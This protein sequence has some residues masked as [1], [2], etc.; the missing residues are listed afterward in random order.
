MKRWTRLLCVSLAV[1]LSAQTASSVQPEI[2]SETKEQAAARHQ[3]VMERRLKPHVICHRGASEFAQENTLEA[4]RATFELGGDGN[5]IDIRATKDGVLV[6]FHDDWL[7]RLL[8]AHG[9]ASEYT[10][11]E[12]RRLPFREPGPFGAHCRI[13]T[14][15]EVLELHR[16]H[17]GLL[18][19]DI[20]RPGLEQAIARLLSRMDMWD[21]VAHC[22]VE[23][24]ESILRDKRLKMLRYKAPGLYEDGR[25]V[26]PDDIAEALRQPGDGLIVGDPRGVILALGR[27]LGRVSRDPVAPLP[28]SLTLKRHE[29]APE[30]Q[31]LRL[32]RD[33]ND[34]N[35][36]ADSE[37]GRAAS[38]KRIRERA[39]AAEML[40]AR[41]A[42]TPEVFAAL[43]DRVRHRSL[44]KDWTFHGF[45]GAMALRA[46]ILMGAPNAVPTARFVLWHDDPALDAVADPRWNNPRAWADFRI[47]AVAFPALEKHPGAPTEKLCRDYL[48]LSDDTA[49]Q[50]GPP[51]FAEAATTLL[52]I[53]SRSET[54]NELLKHRLRSVRGQTI[55]FCLRHADKSWARTTLETSAP[56]ALAYVPPN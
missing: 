3:R 40:L 50:L 10:W 30:Q 23:N 52:T 5:E 27:K 33:A 37:P 21:H 13:P 19:L 38:G 42:T 6:C 56:H 43:E 16:L 29:P 1:L 28:A 22:N 53:N 11:E 4:Y 36:L 15:V 20:K 31:L 47:K 55:L 14:L 34:W 2:P 41:R 46:L 24:A 44:H 51:L 49:R 17:G 26:F 12:L 54:A 18:H 45:D 48:A 35:R 39:W 32:L 8:E 9:D 7:D 25:E